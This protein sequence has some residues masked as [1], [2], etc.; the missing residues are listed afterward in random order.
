MVAWEV[1]QHPG[2]WAIAFGFATITA[3]LFELRT[4]MRERDARS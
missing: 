4:A 1:Y 3:Q 2:V